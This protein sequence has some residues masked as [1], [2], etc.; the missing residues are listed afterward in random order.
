MWGVGCWVLGDLAYTSLGAGC[1][2]LGVVWWLVG[3]LVQLPQWL[4]VGCW[5]LVLVKWGKWSGWGVGCRA[6]EV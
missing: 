6:C 1:L 4:G 5:I 3:D 2:V